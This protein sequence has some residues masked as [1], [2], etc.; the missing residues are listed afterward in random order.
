[1]TTE[2]PN[3][4]KELQRFLSDTVM[5]DPSWPEDGSDDE[6]SDKLEAAV[7]ELLCEHYG[8]EIIDDQCGRPEHRYCVWCNRRESD[9]GSTR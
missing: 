3:W 5:D 6:L 7:N 2:R 4:T 8:H 9:L 1:M